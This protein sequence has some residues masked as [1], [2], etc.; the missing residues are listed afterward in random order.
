MISRALAALVCGP[1]V[2]GVAACIVG[3]ALLAGA[4]HGGQPATSPP[5]DSQV[6]RGRALLTQY[7]CGACHAI[8]GIAAARGNIAQPLFAW[9][10]RSYIAG[11]LP[12]RPEVLARW[13][14]DPPGMVPGTAMPRMGV[15][16][17]EARAMAAYLGT[18]R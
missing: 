5:D 12:N 9:S 1:T 17:D 13:I 15:T 10:R 18:L 2:A 6:Q 11:R 14:V 4:A 3:L 16:P 7:Q 8:P